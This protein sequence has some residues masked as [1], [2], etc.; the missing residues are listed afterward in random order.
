MSLLDIVPALCH[1]RHTSLTDRPGFAVMRTGGPITSVGT[2][3]VL[4]PLVASLDRLKLLL[5]LGLSPIRS[6]SEPWAL[7]ELTD[8][9][10]TLALRKAR[11]KLCGVNALDVYE[12]LHSMNV[13]AQHYSDD[14]MITDWIWTWI[15]IKE[16]A[17]LVVLFVRR[18]SAKLE[19]CKEPKTYLSLNFI[20][21]ETSW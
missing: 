15:K 18:G 12:A 11:W 7:S 21:S 13:W 4:C 2:T 10:T 19:N 5:L 9:T 8:V 6:W 17:I 16:S 14:T 20:I 1:V 3:L